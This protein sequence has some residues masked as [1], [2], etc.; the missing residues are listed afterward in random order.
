[1]V[2]LRPKVSPP[3]PDHA[4]GNICWF[5]PPMLTLQSPKNHHDLVSQLRDT[6]REINS[7]TVKK[8]QTGEEYSKLLNRSKENRSTTGDI[9]N[10]IFS[11]RCRFPVYE[12]D[13]GWGKP[14]WVCPI[15]KSTKN[16][17]TLMSTRSG[18]GVEAWVT[19]LEEDMTM[20]ESNHEMVS[21]V[22]YNISA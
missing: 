22:P 5:T 21:L 8:L 4:F 10:F 11:S 20:L 14:V 6:I 7:D 18:D 13:Y 3:L 9:E 1:M 15:G 2:N 19:M 12:V 17:L 16:R